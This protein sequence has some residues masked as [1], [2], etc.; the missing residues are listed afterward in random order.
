MRSDPSRSLLNL[1]SRWKA[2][3][4]PGFVL[5]AVIT[6]RYPP[7]CGSD[8]HLSRLSITAQFQR[9]NPDTPRA[10]AADLASAVSLFG[11]A[12][13]GVYQERS[14]QLSSWSLTPRFHPCLCLFRKIPKRPSAVHFCGTILQLAL[15]GRY[16]APCPA[17]P[18]LSS[19]GQRPPAIVCQ[20]FQTYKC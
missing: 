18:G 12:P 4:K 7:A 6:D 10:K 9:R 13:D 20:T 5:P 2:C 8:N 11:L 14:R 15:T 17:E 19:R 16:P 1:C 3:H